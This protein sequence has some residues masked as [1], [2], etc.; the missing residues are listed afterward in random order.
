[1]LAAG[2]NYVFIIQTEFCVMHLNVLNYA[3]TRIFIFQENMIEVKIM[4]PVI[5]KLLHKENLSSLNQDVL[6]VN[7][8]Q[9]ITYKCNRRDY[10]IG[11]LENSY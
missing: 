11:M 7:D 5:F 3:G 2:G 9:I 4:I 1:M 8:L 10:F 6:C